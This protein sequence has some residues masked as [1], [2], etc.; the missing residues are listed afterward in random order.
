MP[1][2]G[3]AVLRMIRL[4]TTHDI[5]SGVLSGSM[6]CSGI[7][8]GGPDLPFSTGISQRIGA[9]ASARSAEQRQAVGDQPVQCGAIDITG[10]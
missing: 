6:P 1:H 7:P 9:A 3:A 4:Y 5:L 2:D 8:D 10:H